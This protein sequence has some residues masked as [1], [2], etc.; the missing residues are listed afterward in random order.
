MIA[1]FSCIHA[2][3]KSPGRETLTSC[4]GMNLKVG[5]GKLRRGMNQQNYD[6]TD[7]MWI[8]YAGIPGMDEISLCV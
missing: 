6:R 8:F 2:P 7:M 5:K 4:Y 3:G 1:T